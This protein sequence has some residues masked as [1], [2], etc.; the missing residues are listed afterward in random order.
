MKV[1][2]S[3]FFL[4]IICNAKLADVLYVIFYK[5]NYKN[6]YFSNITA[7]QLNY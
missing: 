6:V 1:I 4:F 3:V 2:D 7:I 5:H